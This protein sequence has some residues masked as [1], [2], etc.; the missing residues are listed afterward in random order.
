MSQ[1]ASGVILKTPEELAIMREAGRI[2]AKAHEAMHEALRAGIS[3]AALDKI[4]ETVIRDHGAAPIFMGQKRPGAPPFP[5]TITASINDELIHGIPSDSRI[6]REGDVVSLDTGCIYQGFVGDAAR[7]WIVGDAPAPV[8]RLV[9]TTQESFFVGMRLCKP[10]AQIKDVAR[11]IQ[12]HIESHGY[13]VVREYTGHGVGRKMWEEPEVP[14][15]WPKNARN[16]R[17]NS[18]TLQAGMTFAIEPMVTAGR[19]D[20]KELADKWTV[21]SRDKSLCAH[22]EN[23]IA[24]TEGEPLILTAL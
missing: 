13:G 24:V 4:A 17:M 3:T 9:E 16:R 20:V 14:N 18:I 6:I 1:T 2:V 23:T 5:A 7:T 10:G 19:P 11:A 8:R 15:W 21:A 12:E 22:Y